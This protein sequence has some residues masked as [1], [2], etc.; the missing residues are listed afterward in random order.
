MGLK[1]ISFSPPKNGKTIFGLS[2]SEGGPI[3]VQDTESR[4]QWYTKP[5]PTIIPR[6]FPYDNPRLP[7]VDNSMCENNEVIRESFKKASVIYLTQTLNLEKNRN[8]IKRWTTDEEI[9]GVCIDSGTVIW[10]YICDLRDDSEDSG[11][12]TDFRSWKPVKRY[13]R[14]MFHALLRGKHVY[15]TAHPQEIYKKSS[16]AG[17]K[18][19]EVVGVRSH[20]E[21]KSGHWAD[22]TVNFSL[23]KHATFPK[24]TIHEEGMGGRG[25]LVKGFEIQNPTFM[26]LIGRLGE[27]PAAA[28]LEEDPDQSSKDEL[29]RTIQS[30]HQSGIDNRIPRR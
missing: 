9:F 25:G 2:M 21:K 27:L 5:H 15:I 16:I 24:M 8:A 18:K 1:T 30:P 13:N 17:V 12:G 26:N 28:S 4:I 22:L 11:G 14:R 19:W 23:G 6:E 20:L 3:G 7:I 29:A 10:D